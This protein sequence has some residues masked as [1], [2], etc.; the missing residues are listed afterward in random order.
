M[1]FILKPYI[2]FCVRPV[3][4]ASS[5]S[6]A[7]GALSGDNFFQL[8]EHYNCSRVVIVSVKYNNETL[9]EVMTKITTIYY[10]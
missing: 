9:K 4:T 10:K 7:K 6:F 8:L 5:S 1:N 2:T 3:V